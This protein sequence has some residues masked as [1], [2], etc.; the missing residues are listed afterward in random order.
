MEIK[1]PKNALRFNRSFENI[2]M[3]TLKFLVLFLFLFLSSNSRAQLISKDLNDYDSPTSKSDDCDVPG[4]D[5]IITLP[6]IDPSTGYTFNVPLI[7]PTDPN[8]TL[9]GTSTCSDLQA[10]L[11][12][13]PASITFPADASFCNGNLT[14]GYIEFTITADTDPPDPDVVTYR[15][16]YSE[17]RA[18]I[19]LVFVLDISGSM[20]RVVAD[21]NGP[22]T[23]SRWDVLKNAVESFLTK[24][25]VIDKPDD[26]V[27]LTY[28][29][30]DVVDSNSPLAE[31]LISSD[32]ST[33]IVSADMGSPRVPLNLTALGKG[34]MKGKDNILGGNTDDGYKKVILVFTDGLQNQDPLAHTEEIAADEF[35]TFIGP[36]ADNYR[37]ND[38]GINSSDSIFYYCIAM[39]IGTDVPQLL[40]ELSSANGGLSYSTTLGTA[41][42][43]ELMTN[44]DEAFAKI[45][46]GGSPQIVSRK[47]SKL[48][49]GIDTVS[50]DINDFIT[51]IIFEL[52]FK[53]GDSISISKIEK[54]GFDLTRLFTFSNKPNS[55]FI[56]ANLNLPSKYEKYD[57]YSKGTWKVTISGNSTN[58]F[59]IKCFVDDHY[60]NYPCSTGKSVY[61]VGDT[62]KFNSKLSFAGNILTNE[63]N[64]VSVL[65]L[66][67]GDDIGHLLATYSTPEEHID[68][69]D[70]GSDAQQKFNDLINS[71][72]TF[73]NAL[74]ANEQLIE[75]LPDENGVFSGIFTKTELTGVYQAIFMIKAEDSSKGKFIRTQKKSLVLKFGQLD[76]DNTDYSVDVSPGDKGQTF[77][78]NVRP[79][80]KFGYYL[81][82]GF[83][84]H[85][86]INF[87]SIG[88]NIVEKKD[89]LDGSYTYTVSN[90]PNNIKP[91]DVSIKIM[92]ELLESA[93]CCPVTIWYFVILVI[94]ILVLV[95][96][97]IK[98]STN[99]KLK[100]LV[101]LILIIWII[102][103]ILRN[104]GY[105]CYEFL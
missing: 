67:P 46:N 51:N 82:P 91:K 55:S 22:G 62:I 92:G 86:K 23:S 18:P 89:N 50:Y 54:D 74:I 96:L 42:D 59:S 34:L 1:K 93:D 41:A 80:N 56:I 47:T 14:D 103:I 28:F 104:F 84:S 43:L 5:C 61:T 24:F 8:L 95:I 98:K 20:S 7:N 105:I 101:W 70:S 19:K 71:D 72:S 94:I 11:T 15:I 16:K 65:V 10:K 64:K 30:T 29:S 68:T 9:S 102:Y 75:L 100:N 83:L 35:V 26:K 53:K 12:A 37:L 38:A 73:Y 13:D 21:A 77:V 99:K 39:N 57:I 45:C 76:P 90:I 63:D 81:G 40:S 69:I 25:E 48:V 58:D 17:A 6:P 52:N 31:N 32:G 27:G 3:L 60:F 78:I 33:A 85:I 79:K 49:N 66:K 2:G 4:M 44:F 88:G 87:D 97:K 36:E